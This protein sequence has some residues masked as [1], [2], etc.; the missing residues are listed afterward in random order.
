VFPILDILPDPPSLKIIDVGAMSIGLDPY[1]KL[2][3]LGIAEV[4]GFEPVQAECDKRNAAAK[5]FQRYLPYFIGAGG[6]ATF[7]EC[8]YPMTSSLYP[9]NTPLLDLFQNIENLTQVVKEHAVETRRLDDLPEIDGCDYLKVDVQGGEV[10]V[11]EGAAKLLKDVLVIHTE[12]VFVPLY[13]G[14]P[15][16][17]EIDQSLRENGFLF[18][19][20]CGVS[21]RPFKP[22]VAGGDVN[23]P[24]SQQLWGDAVY[25]KDFTRLESLSPRQLLAM[26]VIL[27]TQYDAIDLAHLCLVAHDRQTGGGG[28]APAYLEKLL[29]RKAKGQAAGS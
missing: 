8:N 2:E 4:I 26:A 29:A 22:L 23:R 16:F 20:L 14:Q 27:H 24:I 21:G 28:L 25:V 9:P 11:F 12:V 7:Y 10:G 6:P 19:K 5:P 13:T 18:H 1:H 15:L 3:D 17:A